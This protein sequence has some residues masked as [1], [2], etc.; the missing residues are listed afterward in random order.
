MNTIPESWLNQKLEFDANVP[1]GLIQ[2]K[3]GPCGVLS[4][5]QAVLISQSMGLDGYD[6]N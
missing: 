6:I 5:I 2:Y 4:I 3:N 1:L